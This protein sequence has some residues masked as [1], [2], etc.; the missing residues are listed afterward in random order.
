ME[1]LSTVY[2]NRRDSLLLVVPCLLFPGEMTPNTFSCF[3]V[4]NSLSYSPVSEAVQGG[5]GQQEGTGERM[6]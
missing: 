2:V 5:D 4:R 3:V 1:D 6:G